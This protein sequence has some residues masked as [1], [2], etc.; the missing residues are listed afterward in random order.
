MEREGE[1]NE[2]G[3]QGRVMEKK[4]EGLVGIALLPF[5][6]LLSLTHFA[7]RLLSA[8][9]RR[10]EGAAVLSGAREYS[11]DRPVVNCGGREDESA[12]ER[13]G[14]SR[15]PFSS[16]R[17]KGSSFGGGIAIRSLDPPRQGVE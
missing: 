5:P 15:A 11:E 2:R 9:T 10:E 8:S 1:R 16:V 13:W 4:T 17:S 14:G 6:S 7:N 3:L 12:R